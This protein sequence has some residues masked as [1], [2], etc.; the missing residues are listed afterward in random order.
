MVQFADVDLA[1]TRPKPTVISVRSFHKCD[2]AAVS[3]SLGSVPWQV[4]TI[5][6]EIKDMWYF[7]ESSLY[8]VLDKYAP[9]K[10]VTSKFSKRPTPWMTPV[11]LRAIKEKNKAKRHAA[12]T[13][14][15]VDIVSYRRL[16]NKLKTSIHEAKLHYLT[17]LLKESKSN[18]Y[19]SRN[20]WKNVNDIIGRPKSYQ[21]GIGL[22][23]K[24]SLDAVNEFFCNVAVSADHKT[25]DQYVA[26]ST[27][28]S[29]I[30]FQFASIHSENVFNLLQHFDI[31]KSTGP[32]GIS[33]SFLKRSCC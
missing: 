10:T 27:V 30:S 29:S 32:D 22:G 4:M 11:L 15:I 12:L 24:L 17:A 19:L 6:D 28:S 13:N 16:K 1:I 21:D 23:T 25:V 9:L 8:Y 14:S 31:Q 18:P 7:F 33:A 5:F 2:W 26:A 3:R 20:L